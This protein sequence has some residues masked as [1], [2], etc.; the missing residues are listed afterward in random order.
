MTATAI[1]GSHA[2]RWV[3]QALEWA[4]THRE[5]AE[6]REA[7]KQEITA[8]SDSAVLFAAQEK[9]LLIWS[10]RAIAWANGGARPNPPML[11]EINLSSTVWDASRAGV[12]VKMP[13]E[14]RLR[15]AGY[16][17]LIDDH[18]KLS[19][20]LDEAMVRVNHYAFL[21]HLNPMQAQSLIEEVSAMKI[22]AAG[23]VVEDHFAARAGSVF[24]VEPPARTSGYSLV[25]RICNRMG[26]VLSFEVPKDKQADYD[27]YANILSGGA[28]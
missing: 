6:T 25:S 19:R 24:G 1:T 10:D 7:L 2:K 26:A 16:Y 21:P 5:V 14:E 12:A 8:N 22:L 20:Q 9:C 11:A 18:Q 15:F 28:P 4:H 13:T 17:S 23:H 3:E 27:W